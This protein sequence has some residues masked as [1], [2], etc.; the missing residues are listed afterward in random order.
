MGRHRHAGEIVER[1]HDGRAAGRDRRGETAAD[2][3]RAAFARR[4]RPRHNPGRRSPRHRR[5]NAWRV[6]ATRARRGKIVALKAAHL[7]LGECAAPARDPR[8]RP[9]RSGPS[10]DRARCRASARRSWRRR[11]PRPPRPPRAPSRA[12]S[13]GSKAQASPSGIGKDR[14]MAVHHIETEQQRNAEPRFLDRQ[15]SDSRD[16]ARRPKVEQ[17]ADAAGAD[18]AVD[19]AGERPGRS[20]CSRPAAMVS[21][22]IFSSRVIAAMSVSIRFIAASPPAARIV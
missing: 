11:R 21:W 22:P 8:P 2:R 13:A 3:P 5:R 9:R 19:V 18:S 6:A 20:P 7:G 16:R 1:R 17:A 4:C 12:Q 15:A 10:A 14:A